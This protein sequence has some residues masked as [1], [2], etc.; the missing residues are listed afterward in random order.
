MPEEQNV[1]PGQFKVE[2]APQQHME[3]ASDVSSSSIENSNSEGNASVFAASGQ[4]R[5]IDSNVHLGINTVSNPENLVGA[6]LDW[7][8][9]SNDPVCKC[10]HDMFTHFHDAES[11]ELMDPDGLHP[12]CLASKLDADDY[13]SFKE[14]LCMDKV[15]CDKWFDAMDKELQ[16]L[17][18]SATFEFVSQDEALKQGEEI[19]LT[20]WAFRKKCHPSGV[21]SMY[22]CTRGSAM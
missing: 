15:P 8:H 6:T 9:V 2:Y 21:Q 1:Q 19:V 18:K 10:H 14:I 17:F 16:D 7:E 11:C 13:P 5:H 22:V 12:F 3:E 4:V 20:T